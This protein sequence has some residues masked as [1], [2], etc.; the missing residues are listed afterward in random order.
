MN[1]KEIIARRV[2]LEVKDGIPPTPIPPRL[3]PTEELPPV[4]GVP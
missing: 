4:M 2:A 3:K 1:A